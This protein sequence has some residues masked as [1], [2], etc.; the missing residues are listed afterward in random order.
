MVDLKAG[1]NNIEDI[2]ALEDMKQLQ[3][4]NFEYN[5]VSDISPLKDLKEFI[6]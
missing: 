6:N 1:N 4:L 2:S 3:I 5:N